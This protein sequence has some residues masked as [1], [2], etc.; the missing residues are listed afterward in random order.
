VVNTIEK[1]SDHPLSKYV[2]RLESG[3]ALLDESSENL[4]EVVGIL[5]SYGVV[6]DAYANNLIYVAEQQFLVLFPFFKYFN[7]K[8]SF[9][10][11]GSIGTKIALI[12]NMPNIA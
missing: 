8:F 7:G 1:P 9:V 5:K 6:L 4:L 2:H 12:M 10:S 11:C 3:G